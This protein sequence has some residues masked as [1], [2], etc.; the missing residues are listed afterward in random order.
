[1]GSGTLH[2]YVFLV[3]LVHAQGRGS[4]TEG[5]EQHVG[6]RNHARL[7]ASTELSRGTRP[8]GTIFQRQFPQTAFQNPDGSKGNTSGTVDEGARA[9]R[10]KQSP[11]RSIPSRGGVRESQNVRPPET[12]TLLLS[13]CPSFLPGSQP[14]AF[15]CTAVFIGAV[16]RPSGPARA[17]ASGWPGP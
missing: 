17:Q 5:H 12:Q 9:T 14:G 15:P 1:M 7:S 13:L 2:C 11:S 10:R 16:E 3:S 6:T 8:S 4:W